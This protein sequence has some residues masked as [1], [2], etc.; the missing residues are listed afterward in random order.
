MLQIEFVTDG[1]MDIKEVNE[2]YFTKKIFK[3]LNA[4]SKKMGLEYT[5]LLDNRKWKTISKYKK[6]DKYFTDVTEEYMKFVNI[7]KDNVVSFIASH[8]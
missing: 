1:N 5:V 2:Y 6:I 7:S 4:F 3:S 8:I